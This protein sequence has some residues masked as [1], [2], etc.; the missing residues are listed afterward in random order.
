MTLKFASSMGE[1][2]SAALNDLQMERYWASVSFLGTGVSSGLLSNSAI[3]DSGATLRTPAFTERDTWTM[4]CA[5]L[6]STPLNGGGATDAGLSFRR[7]FLEQL[8]L[9]ITPVT[10]AVGGSHAGQR[11]AIEVRRGATVMATTGPIYYSEQWV[12]IQFQ[13][14][15]DPVVGA[16]EVRTAEVIGQTVGAFTTVL[17]QAAVNTADQAVN[18]ADDATI[19]YDV[20]AGSSRWDHFWLF[21]DQGADNNDFP[22]KFLLVQGVVPNLNGAQNDWISQGGQGAGGNA[23]ESVNDPGFNINDDIGRH[24]SENNGDIFIVNFQTPGETGNPGFEAGHP[25]SSAANVAGIIF[26]HVSAMENSG[27]RAVRTIYRDIADV[28]SEGPNVDLNS[29]T[30]AG[31]FEVF[32]LN[33]ISAA[34]F[35]A[36]ETEE[37]QWGLKL[38]L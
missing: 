11:Y 25:I 12:V 13:A 32:E 14:T 23:Y 10:T 20:N 15:I 21:D 26:H 29:T 28:R 31:F 38:Q 5:F 19:I 7:Q 1:V 34:A 30:F 35:T 8:R 24:T 2:H 22:G 33:P 17:Q 6:N 36:L 27:T 4:Q 18:G 9:Y 3:T 37:M 16:F